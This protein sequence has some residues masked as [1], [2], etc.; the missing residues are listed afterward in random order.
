MAYDFDGTNQYIEH[1]T[2]P[3]TDEPVT[4]ACWFNTDDN[5]TRTNLMS[6]GRTA[7]DARGFRLELQGDVGDKVGFR[8]TGSGGGSVTSLSTASFS[9]GTW[10]HAAGVTSDQASRYTYLDGVAGT[11]NT[12]SVS[13]ASTA[14]RLT[15]GVALRQGTYENYFN[16]RIAE[17]AC[18]NVVL[19]DD[20]IAALAN[21][22]SPLFIRPASLKLYVPLVQSAVVNLRSG[23]S[24]TAV[25]TPT[26]SVHPRIV[27]PRGMLIRG[28]AAA[29][30]FKAQ[31]ASGV[32]SV[33]Q[34]GRAA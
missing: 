22:F 4:L 27:Y 24:L 5:T 11:Q 23:G 2:S 30:S 29:A 1:S 25:N 32:N 3:V 34:H 26:V 8:T 14:M 10:H 17:A 19:T 21:G 20:E 16:G 7:T 13:A 6:I 9:T 33:L 18:W 31:Y 12:G 15:V 28:V